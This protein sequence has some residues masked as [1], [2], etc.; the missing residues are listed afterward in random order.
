M[1]YDDEPI[2]TVFIQKHIVDATPDADAAHSNAIR[3]V[4][5]TL[6]ARTHV[7]T[8]WRKVAEDSGVKFTLCQEHARYINLQLELP[9]SRV[10]QCK[11]HK[12]DRQKCPGYNEVRGALENVCKNWPEKA[13]CPRPAEIADLACAL[14]DNIVDGNAVDV[15][16]IAPPVNEPNTNADVWADARR[17]RDSSIP[18]EPQAV[19]N[20]LYALLMRK[21]ESKAGNDRKKQKAETKQYAW[22]QAAFNYWALKMTPEQRWQVFRRSGDI[23]LNQSIK[24]FLALTDC[25]RVRPCLQAA[26]IST[27]YGTGAMNFPNCRFQLE[28][29]KKFAEVL[30][31]D[32]VNVNEIINWKNWCSEDQLA[33]AL[34]AYLKANPGSKVTGFS[35]GA[36]HFNEQE[37]EFVARKQCGLCKVRFEALI[38]WLKDG[39]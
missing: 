28:Q 13:E 19:A 8:E 18:F 23:E 11:E 34:G 4:I 36:F 35:F 26:F 16:A 33:E 30:L 38:Q 32:E 22:S 6:G 5:N 2:A 31:L 12:K 21:F 7:F 39:Y 10:A 20:S 3:N 14:V 24:D 17:V 37:G 29:L 27:G 1:P 15:R 9:W 25:A